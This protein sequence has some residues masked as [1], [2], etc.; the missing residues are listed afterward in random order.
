MNLTEPITVFSDPDIAMKTQ[1]VIDEFS[2]YPT[3][4]SRTIKLEVSR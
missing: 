2:A 3:K 1:L 4:N